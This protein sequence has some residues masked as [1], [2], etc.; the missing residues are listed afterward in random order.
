[1]NTTNSEIGQQSAAAPTRV[2]DGIIC[3]GGEDWWY[4]NRGHYDMQ[5]MREASREV[6]VL[7][8]NSIGMRTPTPSEG[9]VFFKRILRKLKSLARGLRRVRD[10]FWV[11]SPV[12]P[13]AGIGGRISTWLLRL[14]IDLARRRIGINAPLVWIACPPGEV[15]LGEYLNQ[16][17]VVYQRTDKFE[18]FLGVDSERISKMDR[19]LKHAADLTLFCSSW[20]MLEERDS[21]KNSFFVDHGVDYERFASAGDNNPPTSEELPTDSKPIIGFIGGIDSHTFDEDLFRRVTKLLPECTFLL[22]GGCS[23]SPERILRDNVVMVGRKDYEDVPKYMAVS[24]VL[25]MPWRQNEWIRA[26][27]PVKLKEYMATMR[28][29]VSTPFPELESYS[30]FVATART[31]EEFAWAIKQAMDTPRH[32]LLDARRFVMDQTWDAKFKAAIAALS[33]YGVE[34]RA[35]Q[36]TNSI[37]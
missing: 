2:A 12:V 5:M 23:I 20:L 11:L 30:R 26:C 7:Y 37:S 6:P 35:R 34:L 15:I 33:R 29:I 13:P 21:C 31:P 28:P 18:T 3:M 27:N 32:Q 36:S 1:M 8:V 17:G 14:Q 4:H 10:N 24:D 19:R 22:V 25:I 9:T 16:A